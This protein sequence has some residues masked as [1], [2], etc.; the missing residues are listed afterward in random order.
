MIIFFILITKA[1][2]HVINIYT[3]GAQILMTGGG[4][5]G[6]GGR[7]G[8]VGVGSDSGSYFIPQKIT[9]SEFVCPKKSLLFL[10]YPKKSL[11]PF[12][13]TQKNPSVFSCNPKKILTS[14]TNPKNHF[15]PK[16]QTQKNHSDLPVIK[17]CE[18][19][20][21]DSICHIL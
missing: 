18:W 1:S 12:F 14:F 10:A 21:W 17:I 3:P 16:F 4:G 19:S 7:G 13:A 6:G 8:G 2:E 5:G 20:P 15:G 9:T 11:S